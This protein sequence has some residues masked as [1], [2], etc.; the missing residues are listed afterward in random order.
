MKVGCDGEFC[1]WNFWKGTMNQ[2]GDNE[3]ALKGCYNVDGC[4]LLW[5]I[6]GHGSFNE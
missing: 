3:V 4:F 5:I 2:T 6:V 1:T